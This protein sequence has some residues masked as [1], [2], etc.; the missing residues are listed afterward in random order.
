MTATEIK[1][2]VDAMADSDLSV[3]R[4]AV[5]LGVSTATM[6]RIC[7]RIEG[8]TGYDPRK[9]WHCWLLWEKFGLL[10]RQEQRKTRRKKTNG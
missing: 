5:K 2:A 3:S 7:D 6:Y 8:Q 10:I 9:F 4:A 1:A